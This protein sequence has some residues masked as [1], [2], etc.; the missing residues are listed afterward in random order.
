M[1][2]AWAAG[3]SGLPCRPAASNPYANLRALDRR[4]FVALCDAV[5]SVGLSLN[6]DAH[7]SDNSHVQG[8]TAAKT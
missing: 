8:R 4:F 1:C 5:T 6:V 3:A 2:A 7:Y